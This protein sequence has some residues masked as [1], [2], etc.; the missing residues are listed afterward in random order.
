MDN[1]RRTASSD[2]LVPR[3]GVKDG[4]SQSQLYQH[5]IKH[6]ITTT[7]VKVRYTTIYTLDIHPAKD[8]I[9]T[10]THTRYTTET[11][12]QLMKSTNPP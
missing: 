10:A 7:V 5:R 6:M 9:V 4:T 1:V 11:L 12:I 8:D 3:N 2:H